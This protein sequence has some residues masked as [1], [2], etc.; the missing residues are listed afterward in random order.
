MILALILQLTFPGAAPA[1]WPDLQ[2]E[3]ARLDDRSAGTLGVYVKELEGGRELK[4]RSD[5]PWYL[6]STT[7]VPVAIALLRKVEAGKI[8]LTQSLTLRES[9]FVDGS[10]EVLSKKPGASLSVGYL[11]E[12]MLVQS[13]STAADMLI[14]LVGEKDINVFLAKEGGFGT[15]TTILSVRYGAFGELHPKA[16]RLS[17]KDFIRFKMSKSYD[18]RLQAFASR[19]GVQ[20]TALRASSLEDAFERYYGRGQNSS[21]LEAFGRL[22]E[23]LVKEELLSPAHTK[24][25]LRHME[26]MTT[27]DRRLKA[28]LPIGKRFAQKTGTQVARL[29]NVGVVNPEQKRAVVIATCVEKYPNYAKAEELL[30]DVGR[31]ISAAGVF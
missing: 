5:R 7:K 20:R 4:Y 9:D 15:L 6:S 23:R 11:L 24:L 21:T 27:G 28:G 25:V 12:K 13:D 29:C 19:I 8:S 10:G 26:R 3:I 17:N 2:K 30:R 31:A 22:L 18:E 14:R 1:E 16:S